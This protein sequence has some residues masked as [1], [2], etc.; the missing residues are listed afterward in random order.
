MRG[1][2]QQQQKKKKSQRKKIDRKKGGKLKG[3]KKDRVDKED[4]K[5]RVGDTESENECADER[6]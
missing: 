6:Q 2:R 4:E 1:G 3:Y 5:Q